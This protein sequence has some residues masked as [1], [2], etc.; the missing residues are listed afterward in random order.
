MIAA[1]LL[2]TP[3][4][5]ASEKRVVV[6]HGDGEITLVVS[7]RLV[8]AESGAPLQ[9]AEVVFYDTRDCARLDLIDVQRSRGIV[10]TEAPPSGKPG[11]ADRDGRVAIS[12]RFFAAFPIVYEGARKIEVPAQVYP[13][14]VFVVAREGY[15]QL[16]IDSSELFTA[17]PYEPDQLKK[18]TEIRLKKAAQPARP[19]NAG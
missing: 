17:A 4:V 11:A 3:L 9:G 1:T 2:S 10:P 8:D 7:L 13:N 16:K 15:E 14:G 5:E 12:C 19:D 18:E 6:G